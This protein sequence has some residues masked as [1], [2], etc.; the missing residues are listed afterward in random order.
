MTEGDHALAAHHFAD[1][2]K[3]V[4][5]GLVIRCDVVRGVQ[6]SFI[7]LLARNERI[8]LDGVVVLD[9]NCIEF[10]IVDGDVGILRVFVAA[11]LIRAFDRLAPM[12]RDRS[13]GG[14]SDRPRS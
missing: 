10:V 7:D 13:S 12:R 14:R 9:R 6:V 4:L 8:D 1:D 3:G 11:A 2:C 5:S